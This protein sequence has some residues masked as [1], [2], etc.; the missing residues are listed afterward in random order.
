MGMISDGRC[1]GDGIPAR[2]LRHIREAAY[3][4]MG[5]AIQ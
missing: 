5:Q 4:E 2:W 1:R 3:H